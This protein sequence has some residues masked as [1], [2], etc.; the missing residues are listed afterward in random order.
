[1]KTI[2]QKLT[3]NSEEKGRIVG[4]RNEVVVLI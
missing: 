1:M 2:V 3:E 4:V